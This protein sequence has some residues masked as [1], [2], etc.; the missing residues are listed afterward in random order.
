MPFVALG[1]K[2]KKVLESYQFFLRDHFP[3][4]VFAVNACLHTYAQVSK[5]KSMVTC[6]YT[7]FFDRKMTEEMN[8]MSLY[9]ISKVFCDY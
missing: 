3:S 5:S 7:Y 9:A 8:E 6:P 1:Q 2:F 4:R